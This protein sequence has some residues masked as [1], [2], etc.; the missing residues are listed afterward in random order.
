MG[1]K[2]RQESSDHHLVLG[3][4]VLPCGRVVRSC[5]GRVGA[6]LFLLVDQLH[7][8]DYPVFVSKVTGNMTIRTKYGYIYLIY[9]YICLIKTRGHVLFGFVAGSDCYAPTVICPLSKQTPQLLRGLEFRRNSSFCKLRV[10]IL[11]WRVLFWG[12]KV[13]TGDCFEPT[14]QAVP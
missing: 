2:Q 6:A 13:E 14:V 12:G 10:V 7:H 9:I 1:P 5:R 8:S 4:E 11:R 3:R